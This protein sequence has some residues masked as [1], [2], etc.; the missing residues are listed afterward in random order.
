MAAINAELSVTLQQETASLVWVGVFGPYLQFPLLY[1]FVVKFVNPNMSK[2]QKYTLIGAFVWGVFLLAVGLLDTPLVSTAG[3]RT[4]IGWTLTAGPLRRFYTPF[5]IPVPNTIVGILTLLLL[6]RYYRSQ[7]SLLMKSQLRY[8]AVGIL[9][10]LAAN[11]TGQVAIFLGLPNFYNLVYSAGSVVLLVGLRRH[12]SY[13]LTLTAETAPVVPL[14]H[15]LQEGRSYLGRD[16]QES[17]QSFSELVK[18]GYS[19]L[20]ITRSSPEDIRGTYGLQSTPIRWLA[21]GKEDYAIPPGDLLGL[22]LMVKDFMQKATK[23]VVILH[24]LEYLVSMNG[25]TP[26]LRLIQGLKEE[27]VRKNGILFLPLLQNSLDQKEDTLLV[28]ETTPMPAPPESL[29]K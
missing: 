2:F 18:N 14:R 20:C 6:F 5:G 29:G 27:N 19:G 15:T 9:I 12:G 21:E 24:G 1:L 16:Y 17:F 26:L 23:P 22:S 4:V 7:K 8:L 10:F 25:F 13:T 11:L 3:H 28:A